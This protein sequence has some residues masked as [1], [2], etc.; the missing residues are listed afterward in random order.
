MINLYVL[1]EKLRGTTNSRVRDEVVEAL[2]QAAA[3]RG[4]MRPDPTSLNRRA[5]GPDFKRPF[6][7][8]PRR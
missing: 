3:E 4:D 5:R 7:E 2:E 1:A 6:P 8:D